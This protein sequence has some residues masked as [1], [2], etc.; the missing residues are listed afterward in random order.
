MKLKYR[1]G[2]I[3]RIILIFLF[4]F[5]AIFVA[6]ETHFWLVSIW[7]SL[8]VIILIIEL[9]R[10]NERSRK[11]LYNFLLSVRQEDF[12]NL[13]ISPETDEEIRSAYET[14]LERF[15]SIRSQKEMHHQFISTL[16][17]HINVALISIDRDRK[18]H[19]IN[20]AA[21]ELF[22]IPGIMDLKPLG[23][24]DKNLVKVILELHSGES[25][26]L[27]VIRKGEILNLLIQASEFYLQNDYF[28][29]ISFQDIQTELEEKE[30]ESWQ[31]LVRVLTHEI[32][33][34]A[35]PITNL[36]SVIK[37]LVLDKQGNN[38]EP[39]E[40]DYDD[41]KECLETIDTRSKGLVNFVKATKSLT[42]IHKPAFKTVPVKDLFSRTGPLF[43][44]KLKDSNIR[45][46][47]SYS[48]SDLKIKADLELIEQVLINL[49]LN[50][51]DAVTG[52]PDPAIELL[53]YRN[54]EM[55]TIIEVR[56]NGQ[57]MEE[58]VLEQIFIPY[59]TTKENGSGI[60]LSLA[61]QIM[62]LHK[63]RISV[64]SKPAAGTSVILEF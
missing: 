27:K 2:L 49:L 11:E 12:S 23:K 33:N 62:R 25:R 61:R 64:F 60:G 59:F 34:S 58:E 45:L 10:Y 16:L 30:I 26:V 43:K 53:A 14:I 15:R 47:M 51:M 48:A 32:M 46:D 37:E 20:N 18:I 41:L 5:S 8:L 31:K 38:G 63:G 50:S 35:I 54:E 39:D 52:I 40:K 42:R 36:I 1:P 55:H 3:I 7:I 29:L 22:R 28:K 17:E 56:D 19:L 4:G 57:G 9:I 13:Y 44:Q 6:F 21:K 24:I